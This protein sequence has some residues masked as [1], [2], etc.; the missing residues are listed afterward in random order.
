VRLKDVDQSLDHKLWEFDF[1][2][3]PSIAD[4]R[5]SARFQEELSKIT[6]VL[7]AL[8]LGGH[9]DLDHN[10][11]S[12][13][14]VDRVNEHIVKMGSNLTDSG[15]IH[16][17]L[18]SLS[19]LLFMVSGKSD[20]N[21][22]CQFPIYL[23]NQIRWSTLPS[24]KTN[25]GIT[26]ITM[27]PMPR[28][29]DSD[30][31]MGRISRLL[32]ASIKTAKADNDFVKAAS[33]LLYEFVNCVLID[34]PSRLQ[35]AAFIAHYAECSALGRDALLMLTPL[36]MFQV[37]GSVAATGGHEPEVLLRKRML[38]W[39]MRHEIDFNAHDVILDVEAGKILEKGSDD[40][41]KS[42][43]PA[44]T[45]A[46]DFVLPFRTIAWHPVI[47]IQSQFYAGDSGSVSHK[48]VDQTS[49]SRA[50]ATK[51]SAKAWPK[52]N[53]PIFIEYI[54]GAG[55]SAS[56]YGDLKRLL[57]FANTSDFFQVRSSPIRLR[58]ALQKIGFLTTLEVTHAIVLANGN[59][60]AA[61]DAL[62][63]DGYTEFEIYRAL[64]IAS[65]QGF[66]VSHKNGWAISEEY[67]PIARRHM[68]LDIIACIGHGSATLDG[69]SGMAFVPGYGAYH[70]LG[71]ADLD[72][73]IKSKYN[74]IWPQGFMMDLQLLCD[75]GFV[76]LR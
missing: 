19:A 59:E 7:D 12:G 34:E 41:E 1:W 20:N 57:S 39:G 75:G 65:E 36:I 33:S 35:M 5:G 50:N 49:T 18:N 29:I 37:R 25:R 11:F 74:D 54:D 56:L 10:R 67:W 9:R 63:S 4:I 52:A 2:V 64:E 22:K 69:V 28:V 3:T 16:S 72:A 26:S 27:D 14:L 15:G 8:T 73:A 58:R 66:I 24:A 44:K 76:V 45:R 42:A 60:P 21:N 31:Y 32:F 23:R 55:Y 40:T 68:L 43:V 61:R 48:N 62:A 17:F 6:N 30:A 53:E 13:D 70:G 71:L 46:Y 38:E 47:F 51:L